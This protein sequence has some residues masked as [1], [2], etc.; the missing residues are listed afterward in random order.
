MWLNEDIIEFW[1][2]K[3]AE[4]EYLDTSYCNAT[5]TVTVPDRKPYP[6]RF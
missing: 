3:P 1:I 5:L 6:N 4:I 2:L